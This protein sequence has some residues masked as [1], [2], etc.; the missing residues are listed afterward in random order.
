METNKYKFILPDYLL[1][2]D[3]VTALYSILNSLIWYFTSE[4]WCYKMFKN[5]PIQMK[6]CVFLEVYNFLVLMHKK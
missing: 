4:I 3:M 5:I 2:T 6:I 1:F